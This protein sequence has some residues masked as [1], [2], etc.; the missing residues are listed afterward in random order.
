MSFWNAVK[1][2]VHIHVN[3]SE[4]LPPYGRQ[5]DIPQ[6]YCLFIFPNGRSAFVD[7][8]EVVY[9]EGTANCP[10]EIITVFT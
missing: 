2:L 1:N 10:C 6:G 4:I 8:A 3:A 9:I 5:N 7:K